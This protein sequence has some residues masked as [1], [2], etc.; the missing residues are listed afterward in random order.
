MCN[1]CQAARTLQLTSPVDGLL[2]VSAV[3]PLAVWSRAEVLTAVI[4]QGCVRLCRWE[5][6]DVSAAENPPQELIEP[7]RDTGHTNT[8]QKAAP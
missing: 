3:Y 5:M 4:C 7:I 1:P 6:M 8:N 2:V